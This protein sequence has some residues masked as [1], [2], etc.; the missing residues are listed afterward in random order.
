MNLNKD[1]TI[2]LTEE[3]GGSWGINHTRRLLHLIDLIAQD[4]PYDREIV[5]AAAHLH[6]WGGYSPWA[7]DGVDHVVRSLEVVESFLK[8][9][10]V[11]DDFRAKVIECI[12]FHHNSGPNKSNESILL[13]DADVLDFL[14]VVGVLREFSKNPK[15][16]KKA[17]VS[18]RNRREKLAKVVQ[19]P[20]AKEI[21]TSRIK[22]MDELFRAFESQSFGCY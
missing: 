12:E 14:G 18:S 10:N 20:K 5:W 13:R 8:E 2:R 1:E 4:I 7:K 11:P 19:L 6:D 16:M 15:E 9:R 21:A 3:H 17:F 22:E